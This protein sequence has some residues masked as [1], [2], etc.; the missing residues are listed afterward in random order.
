MAWEE[1]LIAAQARTEYYY[2]RGQEGSHSTRISALLQAPDPITRVR[3]S[4][5]PTPTR[6]VGPSGVTER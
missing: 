2:G 4:C 6:R 5:Q 3:V 1:A